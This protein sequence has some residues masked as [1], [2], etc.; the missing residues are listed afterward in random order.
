MPD[1]GGF[2]KLDG[3]ASIPEDESR[4][5]KGYIFQPILDMDLVEVMKN[6][7]NIKKTKR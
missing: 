3:E 7:K 1:S 6:M 4:Q 2:L 5:Y